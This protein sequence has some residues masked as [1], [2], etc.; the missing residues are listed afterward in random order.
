MCDL[1][2]G[3]KPE[4]EWT[5][6]IELKDRVQSTVVERALP[7]PYIGGPKKNNTSFEW[8]TPMTPR[9]SHPMHGL[10]A[11]LQC[12]AQSS[13]SSPRP[14]ALHHADQSKIRKCNLDQEGQGMMVE[15]VAD[16]FHH[17]FLSLDFFFWTYLELLCSPTRPAHRQS[18]YQLSHQPQAN[19]VK[20]FCQRQHLK[21]STTIQQTSEFST[22]ELDHVTATLMMI[23]KAVEVDFGSWMKWFC[24]CRLSWCWQKCEQ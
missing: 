11:L 20:S 3:M 10:Q 15:E 13:R 4:K 23:M 18:S 22:W 9:E 16:R 7:I 12:L 19:L 21:T 1:I 8:W 2:S 14:R 6:W 24:S 5:D 17:H